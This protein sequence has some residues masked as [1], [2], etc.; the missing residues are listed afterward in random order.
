[1]QQIASPRFELLQ[2]E[3]ARFWIRHAPRTWPGPED[4]WIDIARAV[5]ADRD[6]RAGLVDFGEA[7]QFQDLVYLPPVEE[8]A[9]TVVQR[10]AERCE[11]LGVPALR[12]ILPGQDITA[13][14]GPVVIDLTATLLAGQVGDLELLPDTWV[15]WP[16]LPGLTDGDE[17]RDQGIDRLVAGGVSGVMPVD[18]VLTPVMRRKLAEFGSAE[19][20]N[21]LFHTDNP[22]QLR[23]FSRAAAS[24]GLAVYP[25]RPRLAESRRAPNRALAS[26][27]ALLGELWLGCGRSEGRAH[28]F[29]STARRLDEEPLNVGELARR[30]G[31][32]GIGW[33]DTDGV[34]EIRQ[35]VDAGSS[36][37]M[38]ELEEVFFGRHVE[39]DEG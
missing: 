32:D 9:E 37:L 24:A 29:F 26:H 2:P 36:P 5:P 25:P 23:S 12:Q 33:I 6:L 20:Y 31:L 15:L 8:G 7:L 4:W 10:I 19:T 11:S 27:F 21:R 17:M 39:E 28:V 34:S 16:L 38:R 3:P 1:M 13:G 30:G 14:S 18:P 35:F 22:S